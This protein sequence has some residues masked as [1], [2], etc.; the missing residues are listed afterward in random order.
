MADKWEGAYGEG[1]FAEGTFPRYVQDMGARHAMYLNCWHLSEYESAAMWDIYQREGRG[2][3]VRSTWGELKSS[4]QTRKSITGGKVS[5]VDYSGFKVTGTNTFDP[6][7]FKR[8]SFEHEREVRL[9]YWGHELV[10]GRSGTAGPPT[11]RDTSA[12]PAGVPVGG[13]PL[14]ADQEGL[15]VTG[16]RRLAQVPDRER[17]AEVPPRGRR[18]SIQSERRTEIESLSRRIGSEPE[19][20][21]LRRSSVLDENPYRCGRPASMSRGC[22]PAG[23]SISSRPTS[24]CSCSIT[25]A[26]SS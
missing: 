7:R 11:P 17:V 4:L 10:S 8:L 2:V 21:L 15:R 3:A 16:R 19:A 26:S 25:T 24:S 22:S 9:V 1:P 20:H 12:F 13:K 5:Y 6:F 14:G 18:R 23:L